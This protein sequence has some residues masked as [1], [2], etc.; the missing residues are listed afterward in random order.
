[1]KLLIAIA[2]VFCMLLPGIGGA[3]LGYA[4]ITKI[5]FKTIEEEVAM[6]ALCIFTHLG[7]AVGLSCAI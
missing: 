3:F 4:I 7:L 1:M 6:L 2:F 5:K